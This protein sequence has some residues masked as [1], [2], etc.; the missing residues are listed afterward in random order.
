[1]KPVY[2]DTET[3]VTKFRC[4]SVPMVLESS[5]KQDYRHTL[6]STKDLHTQLIRQ[7][8]ISLDPVC[9][10]STKNNEGTH[11]TETRNQVRSGP[12]KFGLVRG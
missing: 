4:L 1:M 2:L 5:T 3:T 6:R 8:L 9:S 10:T 12:F 11:S 7:L